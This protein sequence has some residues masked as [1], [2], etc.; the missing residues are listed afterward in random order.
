MTANDCLVLL[1]PS[2]SHMLPCT[3]CIFLLL[4][5]NMEVIWRT[6]LGSISFCKFESKFNTLYWLKMAI[7]PR[8]FTGINCISL[9][10]GNICNLI[11]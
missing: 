6:V 10:S 5:Y 7:W 11:S 9:G 8:I 2:S 3:D 1:S 4:T